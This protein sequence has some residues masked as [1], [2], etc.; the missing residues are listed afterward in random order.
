MRGGDPDGDGLGRQD[1][2]P[3]NVL[4]FSDGFAKVTEQHDCLLVLC[5]PSPA[6]FPVCTVQNPNGIKQQFLL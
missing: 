6:L 2:K 4:I 1:L 3:A 5:R